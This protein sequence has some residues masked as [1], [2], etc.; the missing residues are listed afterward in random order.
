MLMHKPTQEACCTLGTVYGE[1][2]QRAL[3]RLNKHCLTQG[4]AELKGFERLCNT[5]FACEAD[6]LK[7]L[8]RFEHTL[9]IG[10]LGETCIEALPRYHSQGRPARGQAPDF[11]VYRISG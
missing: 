1:V 8:E 5:D 9:K 6:A 3:K 10:L 7:A 2:R 4:K 11:Y